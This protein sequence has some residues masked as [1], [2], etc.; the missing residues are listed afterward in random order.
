MNEKVGSTIRE[1]RVVKC[2]GN[3]AQDEKN[4]L[5][6]NYKNKEWT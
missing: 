6:P 3:R 2:I 5:N 1:K 4:V